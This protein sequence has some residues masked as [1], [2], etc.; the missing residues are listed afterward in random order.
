MSSGNLY[1]HFGLLCKEDLSSIHNT[2]TLESSASESHTGNPHFDLI[3][4]Q[5]EQLRQKDSSVECHLLQRPR[6]IRNG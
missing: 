3:P 5:A 2:Q 4:R 6:V 1:L